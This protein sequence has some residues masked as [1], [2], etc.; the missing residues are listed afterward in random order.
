MERPNP[1]GQDD[2]WLDEYFDAPEMGGEIGPDEQAVSAAGLTDPADMELEKILK[3]VADEVKQEMAEERGAAPGEPE[4]EP[5][6]HIPQGEPFRDDEYRDTF[7]DGGSLAAVFGEEPPAEKEPEPLPELEEEPPAQEEPP[8]KRRP[9]HK[10]GYGLL[11]IPH[12]LATVVWL[13]IALAIG[14]SLG[15]L[16]WVC[17]AEVLAFGKEDRE[18]TVT[19]AD[20]DDIPAIAQKLLDAGL[21]RYPKLFTFYADFTDAREDIASGTF[22]LNTRYDYNA[23]IDFMAEE[24]ETREVVE[25]V[26]P[27]GYTCA[28]IFKLLE[29]KGVCTVEQLEKYAADGDL[30]DYAG[31]GG[32]EGYWFLEG[33]ERGG[34]YC[35]EGYLYP[36]TYQFYTDDDAGRVLKKFLDAFDARFTDLMKER[37]AE[38]GETF[39][40]RL[41]DAGMDEEYV[42]Q[43]PITIREITIIASLIERE[44]AGADESFTISSVIYNRLTHPE[45][46]PNLAIDAAL[47]YALGL[48]G[49]E[50]E[51]LTE[52]DLAFDSPYNTYLY[53]GL[54]PGPICNPGQASL[55]AALT[56]QD[57]DY[58]YYAYDPNTQRHHFSETAAG[59]NEFLAS[60]ED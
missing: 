43:H 41:L 17:A 58:Y 9:R 55:N 7:G 27:E 19:I 14:I 37:L 46:Y 16:I 31:T 59:H 33:V 50:V 22:T 44:T 18:V 29:D 1:S 45:D 2:N 51:V 25:V 42:A 23:L 28:Q 5:E 57:T 48:E 34:K 49:R 13:G 15:R 30:G 6:E 40:Q 12:I 26:I 8:R 11:G 60:L 21:I 10:P 56:P 52:A 3:E 38:I 54:I 32:V 39:A 24:A 4:S 36:D 35:L 53:P 47:V 20:S